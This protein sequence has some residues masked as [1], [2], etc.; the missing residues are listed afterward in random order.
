M[1]LTVK[2][3]DLKKVQEN[4]YESLILSY[5]LT[6]RQISDIFKTDWLELNPFDFISY[7]NFSIEHE[8]CKLLLDSEL[9]YSGSVLDANELQ[10]KLKHLTRQDNPL[11]DKDAK[12]P[13]DKTK[14]KTL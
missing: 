11:G 12:K 5:I 1:L 13:R 3:Y 9:V 4:N 14:I 8:Y 6:H 7:Q 2:L 10:C